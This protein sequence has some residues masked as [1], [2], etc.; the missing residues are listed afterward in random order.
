MRFYLNE[1][2]RVIGEQLQGEFTQE[3][4]VDRIG[5]L[6]NL[7]H[8]LCGYAAAMR[9]AQLRYQPCCYVEVDW[10]FRASVWS[11]RVC[12]LRR[13]PHRCRSCLLHGGTRN[14][15]AIRGCRDRNCHRGFL[16]VTVNGKI[17]RHSTV[18]VQH[19]PVLL[20]PLGVL[21][22]GFE[23]CRQ[24][25]TNGESVVVGWHMHEPAPGAFWINERAVHEV[26]RQQGS[27]F[28]FEVGRG[29]VQHR[30]SRWLTLH[31]ILPKNMGESPPGGRDP[32]VGW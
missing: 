3:V 29:Q 17:G 14:L 32:P 8:I 21:N 24:F 13:H 11:K 18:V 20:V 2:C 16:N 6:R 26:L 22:A 28:G 25:I 27:C 19:Q 30:E 15:L 7:I 9:D 12:S 10:P 4:P 23:V 5:F 31:L 1:I